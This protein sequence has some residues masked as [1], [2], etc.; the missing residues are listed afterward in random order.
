MIAYLSQ[1]TR[2]AAVALAGAAALALAGLPVALAQIAPSGP[3]PSPR[4]G[5]APDLHARLDQALGLERSRIVRLDVDPAP[6]ATQDVDLPM[7]G[8]DT[9]TLRLAPHSARADD[10]RLLVQTPGGDLEPVAAGPVRT[11]RG[12]IDGFPGATVAGAVSDLGLDAIVRLPDGRR[13]AV[14]PAGRHVGGFGAGD[15]VVYDLADVADDGS[16][17]GWTEEWQEA[18]G[19][20]ETP[21]GGGVAGAGAA[22]FSC[23]ELAIDADVEY[24]DAFGTVE[25]V[26][27]HINL[28]INTMN[29]QYESQVDITHVI[30]TIIV[31]TSIADDPY[32]TNDAGALLG[33]VNTVWSSPPESS[34]Q[35][36]VVQ[37][38]TGQ[39]MAG[40]V[41]GI[42]WVGAVCD[43]L[44]RSVVQILGGL[45]CETD[46]SAHELGHN[47]GSGHC[48]CPENT[49]NPSLTCSNDFSAG[50]ISVIENFRDSRTCLTACSG[51]ST[52]LPFFDDFPSTTID[53]GLWALVDGAESN[54]AA[55]NEPSPPN[56]LNLDGSA[57][58]GDEIRTASFVA[59][60][61]S[62]ITVE[63]SWAARGS[64]S[65]NNSPESGEDLV[66]EY[67]DPSFNWVEANRHLGA[68]GSGDDMETFAFASLELPPDAAHDNLRVRFRVISNND[69][70][71]DWFVD[72]VSVTAQ[73][74]PIN[75]SCLGS[76]LVGDGS[77]AFSSLGADTDGPDESAAC[78][79]VTGS[80]IWFRYFAQCEGDLTVTLSDLDYDA[81]VTVY[82]PSCPAGPDEAL[83]CMVAPG[84]TT[85]MLP[86]LPGFHR[87][88][89]GGVDGAEGTGT[90][91]FDCAATACPQDCAGGGDGNV[92][93]TDLL[94]VLAEWGTPPPHE[95]DVDP[96]GGDGVID[97]ADLL[98]VLAA[99]GVATE[100]PQGGS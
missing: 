5:P 81:V 45:G 3:A 78:G 50:T 55:D 46:L 23:A 16:T 20:F 27:A 15:H 87:I 37:L 64:L 54:P 67:Q 11:V 10:Y 92:D 71:D 29:V 80:D 47:W 96:D 8:G 42:A 38:F 34:I 98:D 26:E 52:A 32:T 33:Q 63:Y 74:P 89:V 57:N 17:C 6:G 95:C 53:D 65:A 82:G 19:G 91:S 83:G 69:G 59:G 94:Q 76:T 7:E 90:I 18:N 24:F 4:V 12:T 2:S 60:G 21:G 35:H 9:W 75:N 28:V 22:P 70:A 14:E 99:W 68:D 51:A 56:A 40:S 41:I 25:D 1:P 61:L 62:D 77:V 73:F 84:Q 93:V 30:V 88:R 44:R 13:I 49:M 97:V 48:S 79:V 58:G 100:C 86:I 85:L 66:V 43:P 36:D 31:R 39:D 72:D